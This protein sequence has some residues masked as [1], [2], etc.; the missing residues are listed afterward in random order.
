MLTGKKCLKKETVSKKYETFFPL[1]TL[2]FPLLAGTWMLVQHTTCG[3]PAKTGSGWSHT[4]DCLSF[5]CVAWWI[6]AAFV[7]VLFVFVYE[8]LRCFKQ[9]LR[10]CSY[11]F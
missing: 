7:S 9:H 3:G 5:F 2:C 8:V 6:E 10:A 1:S 11:L 4:P